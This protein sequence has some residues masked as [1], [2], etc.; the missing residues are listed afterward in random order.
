MILEAA[1]MTVHPHGTSSG[2]TYEMR[3][4]E[5]AANGTNY[6]G[7]KAPDAIAAN[8]MWALPN[9]DG[10]AGQVL[11]TDGSLA[12]SWTTIAD[13]SAAMALALGG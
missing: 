6:V 12:L 4:K 7:F 3:F 2:N 13:N 1:S 5:L 9:A 10:S 8:K 11:K